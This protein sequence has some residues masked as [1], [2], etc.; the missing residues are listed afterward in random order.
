M[1]VFLAVVVVL[2]VLIYFTV[3]MLR[4]VASET[5]HRVD[6]YFLKNLESYDARYKEKIGSMNRMQE[7]HETL[8]R[9]LKGMRNE[10]IANKTSPFYAPR[11]LARDIYIPT[12]RYIDND[13]FE[14]YKIAKDKLMSINKQQVIDDVMAKVPY[15]GNMKRYETAVGIQDELN[16]EAVYDLCSLPREEQLAV[17]KDSLMGRQN[18]LLMEYIGSIGDTEEFE[19]LS[20]LDY[21]KKVR[22][23]NDP[24]VYVSVGINEA[25]YSDAARNICCSVD[26]NICEGVK[27]IYQNKIYDYSIYKT[28]RKVGS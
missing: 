19:V 3:V 21:V 25:D 10:L 4:C 8:A 9:E 14:E 23:D 28:R 12:A 11:P 16:F 22:V 18:E 27:I 17:L 24:H 13:F 5:G 1:G 7:E 2:L 15:E 26:D 6:T 20:F